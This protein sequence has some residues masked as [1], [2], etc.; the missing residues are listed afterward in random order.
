VT[1]GS[2]AGCMMH[3]IECHGWRLSMGRVPLLH[4]TPGFTE[5]LLQWGG[6]GVKNPGGR[7]PCG[8]VPLLAGTGGG[9]AATKSMRSSGDRHPRRD[10]W[11]RDRAHGPPVPRNRTG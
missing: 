1:E 8:G 2:A 5:L 4:A 11:Q 9:K 7:I 3:G 10:A 6:V